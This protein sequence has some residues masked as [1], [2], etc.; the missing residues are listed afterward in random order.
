MLHWQGFTPRPA[1]SHEFQ[2]GKPCVL[3]IE[4]PPLPVLRQEG[5]QLLHSNMSL[6]S[7]RV[8]ERERWNAQRQFPAIGQS[9]AQ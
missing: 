3:A 9:S 1:S 7:F 6:S 5:V 2:P 8:K 4:P